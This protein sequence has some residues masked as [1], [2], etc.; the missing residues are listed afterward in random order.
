MLLD[1]LTLEELTG[2]MNAVGELAEK[3]LPKDSN[4]VLLMIP[5]RQRDARLS[6]NIP[7][8]LLHEVFQEAANKCKPKGNK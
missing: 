4:F 1:D 2:V 3:M 7:R 5:T 6:T 8:D